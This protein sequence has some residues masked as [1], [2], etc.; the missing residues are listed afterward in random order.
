MST[1]KLALKAA[2]AA[3]DDH[4]FEDAAAEAEK[5]LALDPRN[6]HG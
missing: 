2:K 5:V 1:L 3:L 6:Y 4:R